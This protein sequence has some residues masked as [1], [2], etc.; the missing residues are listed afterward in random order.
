[1][2]FDSLGLATPLL[3]AL[4]KKGYTEPTPIQKK[5]IPPVLKGRDVLASAQTG[6]GKTAGFVL[7][8]L[9]LLEQKKQQG[10]RQVRA[11]ILTPTRELAAQIYDNAKI[12]SEFVDIRSTVVFGGVNINPQKRT[13]KQLKSIKIRD[14]Q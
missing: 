6:T 4:A 3:K 8:I 1:M 10:R 11:L 5:A 13:L 7:P 9:Q 14:N 2:S 12:Y